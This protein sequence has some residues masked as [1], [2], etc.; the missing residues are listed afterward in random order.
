[1]AI[2]YPRGI[3]YRAEYALHALRSDPLLQRPPPFTVP[4]PRTGDAVEPEL[5]ICI[6]GAGAAGL[7]A[8]LMLQSLGKPFEILEAS[9]RI[10]GRCF[11]YSFSNPPKPYDYYDV[12]A[13]RFPKIP[14]MQPTFDM[15]NYVGIQDK[16]IPYYLLSR[17]GNNISYYNGY[18]VVMPAIPP[19]QTTDIF[20][21]GV[22]SGGTVPDDI[23]KQNSNI[24]MGLVLAPFGLAFAEDF[25]TGWDALKLFD[26]LSARAYLTQVM[27][28]DGPTITWL[29]TTDTGSNMFNLSFSEVVMDFL[30]FGDPYILTNPTQGDNP[31]YCFLGGTEVLTDAMWKKL[32]IQSNIYGK[33]V[34]KIAVGSDDRSLMVSTRGSDISPPETKKYSHVISTMPLGCLENVD[35]TEASLSYQQ[36]VG[37]RCCTYADSAK[38]GMKFRSRWWQNLPQPIIGG[39]SFTDRPTRTVVYPS[40]GVDDPDADAVIIV[41]Y[42]WWQDASRLG[43]LLQGRNSPAE[44]ELVETILQDLAVMHDIPYNTLVNELIDYFPWDFYHD[45]YTRG[46]FAS[47][48]PGQFTEM[49][50]SLT[51]PASLG[52]LHFAGEATSVHHGWVAGAIASAWRAVAE[53]L[54]MEGVP[55]KDAEALLIKNGF[56][57]PEEVDME[58]VLSQLAVGGQRHGKFGSQK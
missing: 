25:Q 26:T 22:S 27:K 21:V 42:V 38:V 52:M 28:F 55:L 11:T 17:D 54:I 56:P 24:I 48:G 9:N 16:L 40:Y 47:F 32:N 31:W 33:P 43:S 34:S 35:L 37:V 18:R 39:L 49:F 44:Q 36:K 23:A 8:A 50:P 13:M 2:T 30:E 10:G 41:S 58:L 45:Q 15:V 1:M 29:E 5:P 46:A 19:I 20:H 57:K 4:G 6:I 14:P 3:S 53:I 7:A 51:R 12:G